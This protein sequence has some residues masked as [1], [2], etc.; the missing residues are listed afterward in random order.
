LGDAECDVGHHFLFLLTAELRLAR[1]NVTSKSPS[2]RRF[3]IGRPPFGGSMS[4]LSSSTPNLETKFEVFAL[5]LIAQAASRSA[6]SGTGIFNFR[7][8]CHRPQDRLL[9]PS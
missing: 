6:A 2:D 1:Y 8:Y 4:S 7:L 9:S 5:I 3:Y